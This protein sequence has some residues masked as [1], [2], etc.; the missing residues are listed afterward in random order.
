[1]K[2]IVTEKQLKLLLSKNTDV[3]EQETENSSTYPEVGKWETGIS[4]EGPANQVG[5]TK[6]S[7][8]VGSKLIRGKANQ[9]K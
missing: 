7:D 2:I 8:I 4:R 5:I 1:M 3:L 9:L 6:W